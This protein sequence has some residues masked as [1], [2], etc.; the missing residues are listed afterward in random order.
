M[1]LVQIGLQYSAD[2]TCRGSEASSA[3]TAPGIVQATAT[4]VSA[5]SEAVQTHSSSVVL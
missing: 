2:E 1:R 4:A 3:W 5:H